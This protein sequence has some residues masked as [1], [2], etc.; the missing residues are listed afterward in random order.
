M[1]TTTRFFRP[2][3]F[4]EISFYFWSFDRSFIIAVARYITKPV[5]GDSRYNITMILIVQCEHLTL[6]LIA[7]VK[8]NK[9]AYAH[10]HI[11]HHRVIQVKLS[12]PAKVRV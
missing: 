3:T 11:I 10:Y 6:F 1:G 4:I 9:I 8:C 12:R 7:Y 2:M 5:A